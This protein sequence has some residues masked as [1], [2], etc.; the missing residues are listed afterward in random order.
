[1]RRRTFVTGGS[2]GIGAAIVRALA[3]AGHEVVFTVGRS[4]EDAAAL[5][6]QESGVSAVPVDLSDAAAVRALADRLAAA[7]PGY[8][9]FVHCAGHA[10]DRLSMAGGDAAVAALMQV[11][12][13]SMTTLYRALL[14]GM[15]KRR[16]GRVVLIGSVAADRGSRGNAFYAMS[17][18]A[19]GGFMRSSVAEVAG[20]GVTVNLIAP[21]F[22]A[23][24]MLE[25]YPDI[26]DRAKAR[27]PAAALGR[28]A[29][30]S[31]AAAFLMSEEAGY[32]NGAVLAIDGGLSATLGGVAA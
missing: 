23:T 7:D 8:D 16:F 21:G 31:A 5:A 4:I 9:G 6:A 17:K 18:A 14:P 10:Y 3:R 2:S 11:N 22:I 15:L 27:V 1:V 24:R 29:D 20:R 32:I 28:P 25:A 26:H 19:L 12:A 13:L 30:V